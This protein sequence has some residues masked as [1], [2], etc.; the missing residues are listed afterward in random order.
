MPN[1][2]TARTPFDVNRRA[3]PE[4][5]MSVSGAEHLR[6]RGILAIHLLDSLRID[7]RRLQP[8]FHEFYQVFLLQGPARVMLDFQ[9]YRLRGAA[10]FFVSPGQVHTV[11][12]GRGMEG[13]TVSFTQSFFETWLQPVGAQLLPVLLSG[14]VLG[15]AWYG[16]SLVMAV[17]AV[18]FVGLLVLFS[19]RR[20][21]TAS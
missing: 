21:H 15:I 12:P 16:Q 8:H 19:L 7:P 6:R 3:I 2:P 1:L 13:V 5:D 20:S 17:A 14:I 10:A 11:Y 18:G 9:D 4:F